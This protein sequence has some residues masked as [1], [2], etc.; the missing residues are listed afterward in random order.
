MTVDAALIF[1]TAQ[2]VFASSA[3]VQSTD[4]IDW[5]VAQNLGDGCPPVVEIVVTTTF[6]G[7]T[8]VTF[9][10][11]AVDSAGNNPEILD[12][13]EAI[14]IASLTAAA[15]GV[16]GGAGTVWH[17]RM[18]PKK[19]LPTSTKTHLR[20]QVVNSGANTA[21]AITA[22]MQ[23]DVGTAAPGKAYASGY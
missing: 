10:L 18:S 21:G 16:P 1:C 19:G 11:C 6:A 13:T 3:T 2:N 17:L 4:W 23:P 22:H 20:L 8:A 12:S 5:K 7:G 14:P 15:A 9:Q